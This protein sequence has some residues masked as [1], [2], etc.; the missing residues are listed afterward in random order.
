MKR[1]MGVVL[2]KFDKVNNTAKVEEVEI[3][4]ASKF[5]AEELK[6]VYDT[7]F[8]KDEVVWGIFNITN[9]KDVLISNGEYQHNKM[10]YATSIYGSVIKSDD[11]PEEVYLGFNPSQIQLKDGIYTTP[12]SN[13]LWTVYQHFNTE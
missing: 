8:D 4:D 9:V 13:S 11:K 5:T 1:I 10:K 12:I 3:F 2:S 6:E 7:M